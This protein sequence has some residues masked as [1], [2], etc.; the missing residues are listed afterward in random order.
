MIIWNNYIDGG[1]ETDPVKNPF[2]HAAQQ[3]RDYQSGYYNRS[4]DNEIYEP[5][6]R[7]IY[8]Y[9]LEKNGVEGASSLDINSENF[10]KEINQIAAKHLNKN[11]NA[12][13][14][15]EQENVVD[16][17]IDQ[18][19]LDFSVFGDTY[20]SNFFNMGVVEKWFPLEEANDGGI[21]FHCDNMIFVVS[22][23][24]NRMGE[25]PVS[26]KI[27]YDGDFFFYYGNGKYGSWP[28]EALNTEMKGVSGDITQPPY[29]DPDNPAP[30]DPVR[31]STAPET[32]HPEN[33]EASETTSDN[34]RPLPS[35]DPT[36]FK[37][38]DGGGSGG[39]NDANGAIATGQQSGLA[40][41]MITL[42]AG[43]GAAVFFRKH[44]D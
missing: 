42:A 41:V 32:T 29:W 33:T 12:M 13:D 44:R 5:M 3:T 19:E 8:R 1:M 18:L 43:I 31:P 26:H 27:G 20:A 7:Y 11:Y 25:S 28:T 39:S 35:P 38:P 36:S 10:W 9:N 22:F 37:G 6:L 40:I 17:L 30:P 24:P 4:D 2:Y 14:S 23:D 21:S 34:N 15:D 16:Q